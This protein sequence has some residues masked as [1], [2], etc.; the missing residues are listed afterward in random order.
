MFVTKSEE[1]KLRI[2][3]KKSL[4]Y[5][6]MTGGRQNIRHYKTYKH[7]QDISYRL[8]TLNPTESVLE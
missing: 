6:C 1:K 8:I 2:K 7:Y 5:I 4:I 3:K